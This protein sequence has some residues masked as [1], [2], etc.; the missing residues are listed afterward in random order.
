MINRGKGGEVIARVEHADKLNTQ[1]R[2]D[3]VVKQGFLSEEEYERLLI[4]QDFWMA[5]E[6]MCRTFGVYGWSLLPLL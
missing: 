2:Y 3:M 1:F 6:E 5:C 4:G